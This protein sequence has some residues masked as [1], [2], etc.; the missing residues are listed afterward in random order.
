MLG[1]H[2]ATDEPEQAAERPAPPVEDIFTLAEHL[3]REVEAD[4]ERLKSKEA[5][6]ETVNRT[7]EIMEGLGNIGAASPPVELSST[8]ARVKANKGRSAPRNRQIEADIDL[9]TLTVDFTDT[10]NYTEYLVRIAETVPALY[11]NVT[12]VS[13]LL[14]RQEVMPWTLHHVRVTVQRAIDGR[15]DL[16]ERVRAATYRY[17][18]GYCREE[19]L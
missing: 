4:R 10:E 14:V 3:A 19:Y 2:M 6:L 12:Q 18:G 8:S 15:L 17:K 1:G 11:L 16:W 7:I 13:K 9:T 5:D